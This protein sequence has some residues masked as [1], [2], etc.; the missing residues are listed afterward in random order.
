[1]MFITRKRFEEKIEN[2]KFEREE[3]IWEEERYDRLRDRVFDLENKVE[4][5]EE[6]IK[7]L[8]GEAK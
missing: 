4:E 1:M 3:E 7:K 8:K 5:L 2:A 6:E